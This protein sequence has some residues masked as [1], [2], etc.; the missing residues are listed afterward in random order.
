[1]QEG[2]NEVQKDITNKLLIDKEQNIGKFVENKN[3]ND[4]DS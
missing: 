3:V 2:N 1:M 4:N